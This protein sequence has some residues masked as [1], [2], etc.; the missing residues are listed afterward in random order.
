MRSVWVRCSQGTHGAIITG[1][2]GSESYI[3]CDYV[4]V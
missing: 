3:M 2:S 1:I 4:C